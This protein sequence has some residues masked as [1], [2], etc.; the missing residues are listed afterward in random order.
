MIDLA[1][2]IRLPLFF[3]GAATLWGEFVSIADEL[4]ER[5]LTSAAFN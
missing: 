4:K 1:D 3:Q 5:S 2:G